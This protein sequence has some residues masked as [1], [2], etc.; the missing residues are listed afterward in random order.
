MVAKYERNLMSNT[1]KIFD[2][3]ALRMH[4]RR[5]KFLGPIDFVDEFSI[6]QVHER[7]SD[8]NRTFKHPAIIGQKTSFWAK[9]LGL[10]NAILINDDDH[11]D[12]NDKKFDF[13][14]H[15]LS[16]H[17]HDD[18]VGQLIQVRQAL[19]PDGL[20]LAFFFG[21]E[22][23][24][25]LRTAFEQAELKTENGISPRVAPMIELRD[26]GDLLVRAGF[27]LSVADSTDLEVIYTTPIELLHDLRGMG[28]TNIMVDRRKNFL[29]RET[30][31]NLVEL[32]ATQF[33]AHKKDG[34]VK[35]TFQL[36][37]LTG[38]APSKNQQKPL[39][40]GSATHSFTDVLGTYKL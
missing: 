19:E 37:C 36:F 18:P 10:N 39:R 33:S 1:R 20:M 35:A 25:E 5:A 14:I 26:A 13:I 38:W 8:I 7:L 6:N 16:L 32:Y 9:K 4:Q 30:L 22:T 40:R 12:F 2:M 29:K 24:Y 31:R 21:G 27:A 28:E 15:A 11:L 23:L 3:L 34:R 17:W